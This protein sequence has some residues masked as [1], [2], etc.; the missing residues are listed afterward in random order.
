[1]MAVETRIWDAVLELT[2]K[3][4]NAFSGRS[5]DANVLQ[6]D[7]RE[8][9]ANIEGLQMIASNR[10]NSHTDLNKIDDIRGKVNVEGGDLLVNER[11][12]DRQTHTHHLVPGQNAPHR[13][14]EFLPGHV[15]TQREHTQLQH[16][17]RQLSRD[18]T[19][20]TVN[21][22]H[23]LTPTAHITSFFN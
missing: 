20:P 14:L 18:T 13:I 4:A 21:E 11:N 17:I 9:S 16:M 10:I 5:V 19:S 1:M 6:P 15:P 7:Q 22:N 8:F 2:M 3:S 23:K 12:L